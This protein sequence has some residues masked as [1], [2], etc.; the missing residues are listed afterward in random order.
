MG[1]NRRYGDHGMHARILEAISRGEQP[2]TLSPDEIQ[3]EH[4]PLTR[5]PHAKPVRAWVRYGTVAIEVDAEAVAWTSRAVAIRWQAADST[6]RAWVWA[7]AVQ[8]RG[9]RWGS[10]RESLQT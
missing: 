9:H 6:H 7:G 5:A 2:Q 3:L 1:V 4:E 10:P 8:D